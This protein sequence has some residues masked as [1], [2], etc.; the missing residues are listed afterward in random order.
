M[1]LESE[2]WFAYLLRVAVTGKPPAEFQFHLSTAGEGFANL[3]ADKAECVLSTRQ[4]R[5]VEQRRIEENQPK[6]YCH[7]P[8]HKF[9]RWTHWFRS[10]CWAIRC[11]E[12]LFQR[13][14]LCSAVRSLV[15]KIW[16]NLKRQSFPIFGILAQ[17]WRR[18]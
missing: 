8:E 11:A 12:S 15:E 3:I 18:R 16:A 13:L 1:R 4:M 5:T 7:I 6:D 2:H 17:V 9:L 14:R 10:P